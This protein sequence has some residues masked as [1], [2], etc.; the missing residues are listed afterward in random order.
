VYH[1]CHFIKL[2]VALLAGKSSLMSAIGN[3]EL[4][5]PDHV[6]IYHLQR[7]MAPS[8]K[9]ALQCVM[10][11]DTERVRLEREA[12]ELASKGSDSEGKSENFG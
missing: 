4:P 12:E 7:E 9:S 8:D 6:D 2:F 3:R 5:I 10:E 11:V 1:S